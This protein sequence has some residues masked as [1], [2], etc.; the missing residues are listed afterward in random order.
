[1]Q[2]TELESA[3]RLLG[4]QPE[5]SALVI[6]RKY[7]ALVRRYHPDEAA[8]GGSDI[9][10]NESGASA[11]ALRRIIRAYETV[12]SAPHESLK[13]VLRQA[14]ECNPAAFC[15]RMLYGSHDLFGEVQEDLYVRGTDRYFWDPDEE[16]FLL[17]MK[18]VNQA[19]R[20]LLEDDEDLTYRL[21]LFHLLVQEYI[22]PLYCLEKLAE[23]SEKCADGSR[24]YEVSA[25]MPA[26]AGMQAMYDDPGQEIYKC[27]LGGTKICAVLPDGTRQQISLEEDGCYYPLA[28]MMARDAAE[29]SAVTRRV[30]NGQD[31]QNSSTS[32]STERKRTRGTG[33]KKETIRLI[34]RVRVTDTERASAAGCSSTE[35][36]HLLEEHRYVLSH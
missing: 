18:S 13:S 20:R 6:K 17:F 36:K 24:I 9:G 29:L 21:K 31:C 3:L 30:K 14:A 2:N 19:A 32:D 35:I 12:R 11:E 1:M 26:R 28:M 27:V 10:T 22:R 25:R 34:L 33:K 7:R 23:S 16:E 8:G 4:A 15:P 5:D